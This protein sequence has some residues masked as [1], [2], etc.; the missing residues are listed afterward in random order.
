MKQLKKENLHLIDPTTLLDILCEWKNYKAEF[1]V[2]IIVEL[3]ARDFY[4]PRIAEHAKLI[5][6]IDAIC[7]AHLVTHLND[8]ILQYQ[9][10]T[11]NNLVSTEG[12]Y[13]ASVQHSELIDEFGLCWNLDPQEK[14]F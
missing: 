2:Q 12:I 6:N 1:I 8:L 7:K 11:E 3:Q 14:H 4:S 9:T 10:Y 13:N 5:K